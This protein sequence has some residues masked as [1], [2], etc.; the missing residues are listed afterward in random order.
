MAENLLIGVV[1]GLLH[2]LIGAGGSILAVPLLTD[3]SG[4]RAQPTQWLPDRW[5]SAALVVSAKSLNLIN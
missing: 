5:S 2:G 3:R 1:V 4:V